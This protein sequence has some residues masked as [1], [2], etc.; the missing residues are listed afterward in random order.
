MSLVT[1]SLFV[2]GSL[3]VAGPIIIHL[4]NR[5]RF[6]QLDWAAMEFLLEASRRSRRRVR[7][8]DLLLLLLRC[9]AVAL[10]ALLV[11]RPYWTPQPGSAWSDGVR[12]QRVVLLDDSMSMEAA[13]DGHTLLD[14]AKDAVGQLVR[15]LASRGSA[16][17]FTLLVT[18]RAGDPVLAVDGLSHDN[19][20]EVLESV[21]QISP[22]RRSV[23]L[24]DS[25][26][27]LQRT[28][29]Q[30]SSQLNRLVYVVTD[31]RR[32]DWATS[33]SHADLADEEQKAT[34][35]G[36]REGA[37]T[38]LRRLADEAAG[39]FLVDLGDDETG[40][41]VLAEI[42][43]KDRVLA[44]GVPSQFDVVL[45]NVG[46]KSVGDVEVKLVAQGSLPLTDRIDSLPAGGTAAVQFS[47]ALPVP[48]EDET[49]AVPPVPFR[50]EL[51]VVDGRIDDRVE[52]DNVRYFAARVVRGV[53]TLVVD[54]DPSTTSWRSESYYL[55]H[56]LS[57]PGETLAGID[58]H[59]VGPS[60]FET[61]A[62][63]DYQVVF[64]CNVE[65]ISPPRCAS[66]EQWVQQGGG[67]VIAPGDQLYDPENFNRQL[68][69]DG[70]GLAP[71]ALEQ[72]GGSE[73]EADWVHLRLAATNHE[74]FRMYEGENNP[75]LGLVR[76][77]RWWTTGFPPD[78]A[79]ARAVEVVARFTDE[80]QSP[81]II[82]HLH[83]AGR[84]MMIATPL[85]KDWSNWPQEPAGSVFVAVMQDLVR[86]V[87]RAIVREGEISLGAPLR[88][89]L[90]LTRY[91]RAVR[92]QTPGGQS[93]ALQP[94]PTSSDETKSGEVAADAVW[95]VEFDRVEQPGFYGVQL[96]RIDGQPETALFAANVDVG[97]GDLTRID[98]SL[99]A[100]AFEGSKVKLAG[101][102]ELTELAATSVRSELWKYVVG[103][104]AAVLCAE[105]LLG[106]SLGRQR[107]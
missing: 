70:Q 4:L 60:E 66:L 6:K 50:A 63:D 27:A 98:Q 36:D 30:R 65:N 14:D 89:Q 37:V 51:Q 40:N 93:E 52:A 45:R 3:L 83:G 77:F 104:I 13:D 44:A 62:L 22:S 18:S 20:T 58:V 97:E 105:L 34:A 106:W 75:L 88:H 81:A 21:D 84:V 33:L 7:L 41:V 17:A 86:Y 29:D 38:A 68:F 49:Q 53:R 95:Q 74:V 32:R 16:D 79:A 94:V 12:Y 59:V 42:V 8:E 92:I 91:R 48:P 10:I 9:A 76:V 103:I 56:A 1:S 100:A 46:Q 69:R 61:V 72:L 23:R 15:N 31:L 102:H 96:E 2:G 43:P 24:A 19:M 107:Q 39:C 90:D 73:S 67:L 26:A 25:F 64:L 78:P 99:L 5:R 71:V 35:H 57:P 82:E 11:A 47:Y 85:D 55:K 54:G 28:L 87:A 80:R 101:R